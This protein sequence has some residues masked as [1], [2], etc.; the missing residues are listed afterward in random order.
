MSRS[1][2]AKSHRYLF[3]SFLVLSISLL[4]S[5]C[6][7]ERRAILRLTAL[8]FKSQ[9]IEAIE[10]TKTIYQLSPSARPIEGRRERLLTRLL[11]DNS[12]DFMSLEQM[13][14]VISNALGIASTTENPVNSVLDELKL[15]YIVAAETFDNLERAGL[16]GTE[17]GAVARAAEPARRL[18]VKMAMLAELIRQHPPTPR[19]ADR[20]WVLNQFDVL[21]E[22]Y[23][24]ADSDVERQEIRARAELLLDELLTINVEE[25]TMICQTVS[26]LLVTV[27]TGAQLSKLIEDYNNLSL[28]EIMAKIGIAFG[29]A[30]RLSDSDFTAVTS[31]LAEV[32]RAIKEDPVL[33]EILNELPQ[34]PWRSD[35]TS[36]N[37]LECP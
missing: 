2:L 31:Q 33:N 12:L 20:V 27:Q 34:Q 19:S 15:E 36:T 25:T 16:L 11:T 24:Q 30:S 13:D 32:Q 23:A 35:G 8:N 3:N 26:K 9:A 14:S 21:R 18:T 5:G 22:N 1:K 17:A 28:D 6:S 29:I 4:L 7:P 10:A 37:V